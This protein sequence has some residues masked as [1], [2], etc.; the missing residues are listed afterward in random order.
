[1]P[2]IIIY[3]STQNKK[4]PP[5]GGRK[6]FLWFWLFGYF[7]FG[8]SFWFGFKKCFLLVRIGCLV[9]S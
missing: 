2:D 3:L 4:R 1:M 6:V 8:L 5:F 7:W 9:R